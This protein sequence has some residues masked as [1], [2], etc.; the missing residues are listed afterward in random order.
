MDTEISP[1]FPTT[2][3][4]I[5]LILMTV[6]VS[7][8]MGGALVASWNEPQVASRLELYQTDLLLQATA[9][10]GDGFSEEQVTLLR[11]NLLG[12]EP[13]REAQKTYES[14]RKT[15]LATLEETTAIA[16]EQSSPRLQTALEGQAELLDLL[17]L[18][19]GI[20]EAEQG[21]VSEALTHWQAVKER[22]ARGSQLWLT[23]DTLTQLWQGDAVPADSEVLL[24]QTL[25]GWFRNRALEELYDRTQASEKLAQIQAAE[26]ENAEGL[27]IT[28]ATVGVLPAIGSLLGIGLLIFIGLQ[29]LVKGAD[30]LLARNRDQRWET[31]WSAET[32]WL[33]VVG[34]FL[35]MGQLVVP[36]LISPLRGPLATQGIR[37]QALFALAYYLTMSVGAIAV[38]F[39]ALRSYRPLPKGW[40]RFNF[41][42][43]W[44]LWGIG[45]YI[46]ALPLMLTVSVLNQ[47]IWQGQ[48]GS[49]PLLQTVLEA[50]DPAALTIFFITASVA[51]PLFE[52][53]LFRGFLLPSLTR[54][55]SVGNAIVLSSFVFAIAHLS[56]S[57]V[58]PLMVL[59]MILGVVYTRSRNLLAPMLLHSAWNSIT[60]LG[61]FL[62][63]GSAN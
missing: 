57:E 8:L 35:F 29:R 33:V 28:L 47:Q 5:L 39:F 32:I 13:L 43:N 16:P 60:M 59:G 54:Y 24:D 9:W 20:L 12:E 26:T 25:Q 27:L 44:F 30:S 1:Q 61:L 23:A 15:A 18:R 19:L 2:I 50:Q 22:Q 46:V 14:V 45:G 31:P 4:R 62:L 7:V 42:S 37:G 53:F 34:G 63:G 6:I 10:E 3:R 48:G 11:R 55:M 40:F 58:L 21:N 52:E 38:L 17:D 49:N 41:R 36:L 51:A 56:L